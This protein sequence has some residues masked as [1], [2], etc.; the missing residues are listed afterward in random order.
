MTATGDAAVTLLD[1]FETAL[2]ENDNVPGQI[3]L[4]VGEVPFSIGLAEDLCC[5]G[6][7]WV[8]VVRTYPSVNFPNQDYRV[9]DCIRTARAT[10]FEMGVVRC[11]PDHGADS[12]ATCAEWT[13][14][15]SQVD[16]DMGAMRRALCCF[17]DVAPTN[18]AFTGQLLEGEWR[19]INGD[20]GCIGGTLNV[21]I[22]TDCDEC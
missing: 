2:N 5:S 20:G 8:R 15:F 19:P 6:L 7:A 16:A 21:T 17:I 18:P 10:E 12:G 22:G 1:C 9:D 11:L 3:C 14:V 13:A 4:R